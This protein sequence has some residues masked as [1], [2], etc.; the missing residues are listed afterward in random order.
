MK[1]IS[2]SAVAKKKGEI[3]PV[4]GGGRE[5]TSLDPRERSNVSLREEGKKPKVTA[6]GRGTIVSQS[7]D[8]G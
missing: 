3:E 8:L 5:R 1:P 4:S 2:K 6:G 7:A